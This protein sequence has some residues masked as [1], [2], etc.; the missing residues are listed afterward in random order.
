MAGRR[1][2]YIPR[3]LQMGFVSN[4]KK[5]QYYTFVYRKNLPVFECNLTKVGLET[6]FY[7]SPKKSKADD[8]IT[9]SEFGYSCFLE[10]LRK[11]NENTDLQSEECADFLSHLYI[12]GKSTRSSIQ[13][14]GQTFYSAAKE[15][16]NQFS[17]QESLFFHIIKKNRKEIAKLIMAKLPSNLSNEQKLLIA[18]RCLDNPK[19]WLLKLSGKGLDEIIY[20]FDQAIGNIPNISKESHNKA[21]ED[22]TT[23]NGVTKKLRE[24]QWQLLHQIER[25]YIYGDVGP[26]CWDLKEN[27][28]KKLMF[29]NEEIQS[30]FMP[31]SEHHLLFGQ[32]KSNSKALPVVTEVNEAIASLSTEFFISSSNNAT[33]KDLS[34]LIGK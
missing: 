26:I 16:I 14:I 27:K 5:D 32:R 22:D 10:N 21:L 12:R 23:S 1:H 2:H 18:K 11:F 3:F 15:N 7:G 28:F 29:I 33:M 8:N 31:I 34:L 17:D 25:N 4:R 9:K 13:E 30:V 19:E 24:F 20:A 6:D